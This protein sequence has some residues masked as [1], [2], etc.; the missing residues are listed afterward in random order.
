MP[1]IKFS[2]MECSPAWLNQAITTWNVDSNLH[3]EICV[4]L[5]HVQLFMTP[6]TVARQAP[7]SVGILQQE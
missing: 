5:S 7:L 6:W 1:R 4:S 2:K 3:P